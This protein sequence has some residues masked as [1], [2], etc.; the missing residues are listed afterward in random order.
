MQYLRRLSLR[1]SEHPGLEW[2]ILR[3]SPKVFF[4][5]TV[6]LVL[7]ILIVQYGSNYPISQLQLFEIY[8]LAGLSFLWIMLFTVTLYAFIIYLMKGPAFVADAYY[9]ED[10]DFPK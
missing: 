4:W 10:S 5:G 3:Y 7:S 1:R 6:V 9:L 8:L 2:T